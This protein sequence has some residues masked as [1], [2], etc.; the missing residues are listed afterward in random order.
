MTE[1]LSG[2][3]ESFEEVIEHWLEYGM[4]LPIIH[5]FAVILVPACIKAIEEVNAYRL[6]TVIELPNGV[7]ITWDSGETTNLCPAYAIVYR[8]ELTNWLKEDW[9]MPKKES[10]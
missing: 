7:T 5:E 3:V 4:N 9:K 10:K 2:E 6:D 1:I 8:F